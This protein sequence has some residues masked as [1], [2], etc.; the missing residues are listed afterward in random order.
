MGLL[1]KKPEKIIKDALKV[2]GKKQLSLI[3]HG[4]SFPDLESEDTA[5]GSYNSNGAKSLIDYI[6]GTFNSIQLGPNGKLKSCDS[7]PYTSTIFSGNPLFINLKDL[8]TEEWDNILSENTFNNIVN[9]N[10]NKNVNKTAFSYA[11]KKHDEALA[12]AYEN[13]LK[14]EKLKKRRKQFDI[15]KHDNAKWLDKDAVYQALSVEH[16]NDYWP[17]WKS[18]TDKN[19]FAP[20]TIE[21]RMAYASRIDEIDDIQYEPIYNEHLGSSGYTW[22]G[23]PFIETVS[24]SGSGKDYYFKLR[25]KK[26]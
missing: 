15:Y 22:V 16:E 21:E 2:L 8:T 23:R 1:D 19:L 9:E 10:P 12:E 14:S 11:Y 26:Q 13:F 17:L 25:I 6:A 3:V 20:K 4:S 7:S 24:D 5:Y 18:E